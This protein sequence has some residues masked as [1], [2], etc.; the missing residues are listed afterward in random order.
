MGDPLASGTMLHGRY[1]V[2]EAV[3]SGPEG[4]L[5]LGTDTMA[6]AKVVVIRESSDSS[7]DAQAS[8]QQEVEILAAL[9][10]PSLPVVLDSFV[11][12]SS[13]SYLVLLGYAEPSL[14]ATLGKKGAFAQAQ[15]LEWFDRVLDAVEHLHAQRPPIVHGRITPERIVV[16]VDGTP[17]LTGLVDV[18]GTEERDGPY[19]AP[20]QHGGRYDE[21]SDVYGLGATLYTLLT[22]KV[23]A[24]AQA[25]AAG[26]EL[27]PPRQVNK[28]LW[29]AVEEVILKAMAM[30]PDQRFQSAAQLRQA[31]AKAGPPAG[32]HGTRFWAAIR[33]AR[34]RLGRL[35][36]LLPAVGGALVVLFVVAAFL[37]RL[38]PPSRGQNVMPPPSPAATAATATQEPVAAVE[39]PTATATT[40][41]TRAPSATQAPSAAPTVAP[42]AIP[43]TV[44]PRWYAGPTASATPR[45]LPAPMLGYPGPGATFVGDV[46]FRWSWPGTLADDEYFD[47]QVYRIGTQPK[48]IA[49]C[50]E[51]YYRTTGLL[52]GEGQYLWRVQIVCGQGGEVRA[53]ASD[54]S[55]ERMLTW[56][57][58]RP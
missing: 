37:S 19:L 21:R 48:G 16:S 3:Q 27:T 20:E 45:W 34:P 11:E 49:W 42:S 39:P 38:A 15:L 36:R 57:A 50:K 40:A 35:P 24:D 51:P 43:P 9:E 6:A 26:S 2:T 29:P 30:S 17:H 13:R 25:R 18:E 47:L 5:Y 44:A 53:P 8:F 41:P 58:A 54:P 55:E 14:G 1:T 31:L 52:L 12:P 4:A 28:A 10:H 33:S 46:E 23:P 22:A 56:R 7:P 32:E